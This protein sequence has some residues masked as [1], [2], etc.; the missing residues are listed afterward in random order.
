MIPAPLAWLGSLRSL[1]MFMFM[2]GASPRRTLYTHARG[3]PWL[4][5]AR[6]A[7]SLS[8]ATGGFPRAG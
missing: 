2:R 7:P 1:F 6:V 5:A 4:R 3:D 8:L